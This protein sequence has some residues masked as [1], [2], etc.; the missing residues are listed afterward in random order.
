MRKGGILWSGNDT[1]LCQDGARR[2]RDEAT[3]DE[4]SAPFQNHKERSRMRG[5]ENMKEETEDQLENM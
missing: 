4:R 2:K 5:Q 3:D 1:K